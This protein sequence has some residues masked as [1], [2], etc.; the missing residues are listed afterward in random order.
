MK[1]LSGILLIYAATCLVTTGNSTLSILIG[2]F[3]KQ[4]PIGI[5]DTLDLGSLIRVS[6]F[7]LDIIPPS[8]G[9]QFY[10]NGIVFLSNSKAE[11]KMLESHTSF[12][13]VEAY[14]AAFRDT[15]LGDHVLFSSSSVW[16]IPCDAMTFNSD[17]SVMYFTKKP[18]NKENEKIYQAKYQTVKNGDLEWVS[19]SKPLSFCNDKST[20]SNPTLSNDGEKI[21]FT[22]NRGGGIGGFD[23]YISYEDNIGWSSPINLGNKINTQG[24]ENFPFLDQDNN[25][26]FSS[27]GIKGFGG[28][29]I[30][31]CRYTGNGWDKP[32][33]LSHVI[34]TSDDDLAFT[35]SRLDGKS[36]FFTRR[37]NSGS[38]TSARLIRITFR[39]QYALNRLTYLSNAFKYLAQS[40]LNADETIITTTEK[41]ADVIKAEQKPVTE[42]V[43]QQKIS[44][45]PQE[46]GKKAIEIVA[47]PSDVI[48]YRVQFLSSSKPSGKNEFSVAGKNYKTFE[49]L[50][51]G[52][53]RLCAGN[54]SSPLQAS[55]LQKKMKQ[56]GYADAFVVAFKNNIRST[57]P[58]YADTKSQ[59]QAGKNQTTDK[60]QP[61]QS[62]IKKESVVPPVETTAQSVSGIVYRI[63][64]AM[65]AKP[66]GSYEITMAGRKY[67][68]YEYLYNGAYRSCAGEFGT[69]ASAAELQKIMKKQGYPDAFIV[70]F[71]NNVRSL[72]P[73]LFKR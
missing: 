32:V 9:I 72:D 64:F 24:N 57:E 4:T 67:R 20:Y 19:D 44:D 14:Y 43:Q 26:Y 63:Q 34:N 50:F 53:Y 17:Y 55:D 49:Y 71:K 39:D 38:T 12:G 36:A 56:A 22:S 29:D 73:E 62:E 47:P 28:Y 18:S 7:R 51:N 46:P 68:T 33:N 3:L 8:S 70:A 30:Y 11:G 15:S 37:Y 25:L 59:E 48:V 65:S 66:K 61:Q 40:G 35:L 13:T 31:F 21:V 45:V 27:D 6:G 2:P 58:I 1:R 42:P 54:F 69:P 16:A 41:Q 10:R 60:A 5:S 23:L 52:A